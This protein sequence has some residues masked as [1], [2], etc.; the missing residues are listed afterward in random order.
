MA[1]QPT[2]NVHGQ[3]NP[4][5]DPQAQQIAQRLDHFVQHAQSVQGTPGAVAQPGSIIAHAQSLKANVLAG[6]YRLAFHDWCDVNND[7]DDMLPGKPGSPVMGAGAQ[8]AG[9]PFGGFDWKHL[10]IELGTFLLSRL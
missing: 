4:A 9:A 2:P 6:E 7:V 5:A 3:P 8:A 1:N 10:L